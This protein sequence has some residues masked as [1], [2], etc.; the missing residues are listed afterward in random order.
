MKAKKIMAFLICALAL[1][2]CA[3]NATGDA[4]SERST[5]DESKTVKTT[6][7]LLATEAELGLVH[8]LR[9]ADDVKIYDAKDRLTEKVYEIPRKLDENHFLGLNGEV[10]AKDKLYAWV[11]KT[12]GHDTFLLAGEDLVAIGYY[13]LAKGAFVPVCHYEGDFVRVWDENK[14]P[15]PSVEGIKGAGL[16]ALDEERLLLSIRYADAIE[17]FIYTMADGSL[18]EL[19][20][21]PLTEENYS[22]G[23]PY[24]T[25]EYLYIPEPRNLVRNGAVRTHIYDRKT[26]EEVKIAEEACA[27]SEMG[28]DLLLYKGEE[29]YHTW[30][31]TG[32]T[33]WSGT[34]KLHIGDASYEWEWGTAKNEQLRQFGI[35]AEPE[36]VYTVSTYLERNE[37][38]EDVTE[39]DSITYDVTDYTEHEVV[40]EMPADK[41][42][43]QISGSYVGMSVGDRWIGFDRGGSATEEMARYVYIYIPG[44][45]IALRI[46]MPEPWRELHV[47]PTAPYAAIRAVRDDEAKYMIYTYEPRA[48]K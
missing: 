27:A 13:D 25:R 21:F 41:I 5:M 39:D 30:R 1:I 47:L 4:T 20:R 38:E 11:S 24:V 6:G 17:Y 18:E 7:K 9:F 14:P 40:R 15:Y 44:E 36:A 34:H 35:T 33:S 22:Y 8:P 28:K 32:E 10:L 16:H 45:K 31:S 12:E 29:V 26:L 3:G 43:A 23:I 48:E 37:L 19:V 46:A 2:S 42:I